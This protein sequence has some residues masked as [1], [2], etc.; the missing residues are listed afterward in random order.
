M[1]KKTK[2]GKD[3]ASGGLLLFIFRNRMP[4]LTVTVTAIVVSVIVSLLITDRYSSSVILYPTEST[5][6]SRSI[7]GPADS[8]GDMMGFGQEAD[9]ERLLQVLNSDAI[10]DR[11][12]EKY[13]LMDHYEIDKEGRYPYT[14]LNRKF[15]ENV[16]FSKTEFMAVEIEVLDTDATI[17][18]GMANDIAGLIDTVM[19][20]MHKERVLK[21]LSIVQ[22]EY[23][24]LK[25][26]TGNL[27]DSLKI[28]RGKGVLDYET[29]AEVLN[30]AYATAVLNKD[31]TG[32]YFFRER[33]NNLMEWGGIYVNLRGN[34]ELQYEKLSDLKSVYD[35][36][37]L[38]AENLMSYR[39]IVTP[40]KV[41]EKSS[42]PV[43]SLIVVVSAV[44]AFIL[45][46]FTLLMIEAMKTQ[47]VHGPHRKIKKDTRKSVGNLDN[48]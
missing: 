43:R 24:R 14:E 46:L 6:L 47:L 19:N 27:E 23:E 21:S 1:G 2:S 18:A 44:A 41:S 30:N 34:L 16:R 33:I 37:R 26:E 22:Q 45:T 17:A 31:T 10:R 3:L 28:I 8:R 13:S 32:I 20:N 12:V 29:Q 5:S 11:I 48:R 25:T 9:A 35:E 40:A 15:D 38:N 36:T 4:L 42:Y 39:F 7:M